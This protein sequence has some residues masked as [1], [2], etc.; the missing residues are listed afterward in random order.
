MCGLIIANRAGDD[1][2][3]IRQNDRKCPI[4]ANDLAIS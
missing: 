4:F 1:I 2:N 3:E